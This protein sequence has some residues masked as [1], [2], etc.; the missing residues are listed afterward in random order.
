M[1]QERAIALAKSGHNI[2]LTGQAGTGKTYTL[3]AI[4]KELKK[5]GKNI[6]RTASTGIA[7]THISGQTIHSWAGIGVKSQMSVDNLYQIKNNKFAS[8]RICRPD[9]LIIDEISMLPDY[10]F[11]LVNEVCCF[12]RGGNRFFG[13]LQV[14]CCGDFFQLPPV[15]QGID[16]DPHY[17]FQSPIFNSM[18]FKVCYLD[19]IYRQSDPE[20][21]DLLNAIRGASIE[22]KHHKLLRSLQGNTAHLKES[23][24]LYPKNVNV[25]IENI[26]ELNRLDTEDY[27]FYATTS[28]VDFIAQRI[29]KNL[30]VPDPLI[31]R[32]G[33]KCMIV[34]NKY[35]NGEAI[36]VNGTLGT[37]TSLKDSEEIEFTETKTGSKHFISRHK[38]EE[39]EDDKI[40]ASVRHF[41]LKLAWAL[42]VHK[43]QGC[44]LDYVDIDL[45]D[46]FVHNMGY[47]ALS[48][49]TSLEGLHLSGYNEIS[50]EIDPRI[51]DK[52]KEFQQKSQD[53]E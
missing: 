34:V 14:I 6:A 24:R 26:M 45:S 27:I 3:N 22:E 51:L 53:N 13:G 1:T 36:Y 33:A 29:K 17:C 21:I 15:I 37:V 16:P 52:D 42:T 5:A 4:I 19:H 9:V 18:D 20:F 11:N 8:D 25:D 31:L 39:K 38:W 41:P 40:V 43:S 35:D 49:C 23:V 7:S 32:E 2:L 12:I 48:R 10:V 44:S 50:L 47:V 46:C 28:G 30:L